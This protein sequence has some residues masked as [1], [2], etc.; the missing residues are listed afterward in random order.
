MSNT[1][2]LTTQPTFVES[3]PAL[4]EACRTL[5]VNLSPGQPSHVPPMLMLLSLAPD[6]ACARMAAGLAAVFAEEGT[7]TLLVDAGVRNPLVHTLFSLE[8]FPGFVDA[9]ETGVVTSFP[10]SISPCLWVLPAGHTVTNPAGLYNRPSAERSIQ[11]LGKRFQSIIFFAVGNVT[12]PDALSLA[13]HVHPA[14]LL[15]RKGIDPAD[16]I[17][18]V[19][20]LQERAGTQFLGFA[21][22]ETP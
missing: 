17:Q 3:H 8:P 10:T 7:M 20:K 19:V 2:D 18:R 5:R 13:A 14:V 6:L 11:A 15:V 1:A 16:Q 9:L 12:T 21:F 22:V 4:L